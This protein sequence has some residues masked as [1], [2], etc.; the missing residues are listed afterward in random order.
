MNEL[1]DRA[2]KSKGKSSSI[3]YKRAA[4]IIE[5]AANDRDILVDIGCGSANFKDLIGNQVKRYIGVDAI[6]YSDFSGGTEFIKCNLD[7][8]SVQ[9]PDNLA[10]I[11][12]AIEVIEH[13]ENPR[14]L[15]REMF[16]LAKPQGIVLVSTPNNI[17][18]LNKLSFV[19][20]NQFNS[21]QEK[22]GLYPAH[23]TA[24]LEI[25]LKRIFTEAGLGN[26]NIFYSDCGRIP[27]S[28]W[29]WPRFLKG[30]L[31][32]DNIFCCGTKLR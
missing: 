19:M 11:V 7:R 21:F 26:I 1:T 32:S 12:C 13:V 29:H 8:E 10:D 2:L 20:K 15:V 27:I 6:C 5:L 14:A 9:L 3:I 23:I 31:F 22:P 25:D 18:L 16:R 30:S 28:S 4:E 17:N 24:L